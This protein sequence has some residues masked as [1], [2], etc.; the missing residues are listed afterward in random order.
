M[1]IVEE[2]ILAWRQRAD[3]DHTLGSG[4]N[5]FL[6]PERYAFEFHGGYIEIL[7]PQDDRPIGRR[8]DFARLKM[9]TF[10]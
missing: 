7:D 2:F 6:D 1:K 8:M 4:G 5:H 10:D 9:M 3:I